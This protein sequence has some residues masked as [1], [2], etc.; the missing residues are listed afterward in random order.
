[1]RYRAGVASALTRL[2]IGLL[3]V[4]GA[5]SLARGECPGAFDGGA[6]PP[7]CAGS[8]SA[9]AVRFCFGGGCSSF[10][11]VAEVIGPPPPFTVTGLR[12]ENGAGTFPV[13]GAPVFLFP[14]NRLVIDVQA[15]LDGPGTAR[16]PLELRV[17]EGN[18]DDDDD[19][20]PSAETCRT[21]LEA[22]VPHCGPGGGG[23][24]DAGSGC[25]AG[26]CVP[27]LAGGVCDDGDP[28]TIGD[29]CQGG[30]CQP[31]TPKAC[32]DDPCVAGAQCVAGQCV[33]GTPLACDDG[34]PCTVDL[35]APGVG[36]IHAPD[37]G[38]CASADPCRPGRCNPNQGCVAQ[39]VSGPACD[40]AD[41]CTT[42]DRCTNGTCR[43]KAVVCSDGAACTD[44]R[45]EGGACVHV[46]VDSRCDGGNCTVGACRPGTPG[47]DKLGCVSVPVGEGEGCTDDGI[48]CTDDVC[49]AGGCLH[50]PVD[51]NCSA[52]TGD[53]CVLAACAPERLDHDAAGCVV[54]AVADGAECSED[55]DP[56][57]D[58]VCT[59]G[60]CRHTAV[61]EAALCA[62]IVA[63]FRKALGLANAA[64]TLAKMAAEARSAA[65]AGDVA[66]ANTFDDRLDTLE[67]Q[68]I[69]AARV[70]AGKVVPDPPRNGPLSPT[71]AQSRAREALRVL[72][73][74]PAQAQ[75]VRRL[76]TTPGLRK[77]VGGPMAKDLG[78]RGRLLLKGTKTLK[79]DLRR[80]LRFS[81]TFA[82]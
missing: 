77:A 5:P 51:Q 41:A 10:G 53:A 80:I 39:A 22:S 62:P 30:A 43:G 37:D 48:P 32:V 21:D 55:G 6:L 3:V 7:A 82:R 4:L 11:M 76:A 57:S 42:A 24:C 52:A 34:I 45:C 56:C 17:R 58:D 13:F 59:A 64:R 36:C 44:D 38:Q 49:T 50:V 29:T 66:A 25:V 65:G 71:S 61:V 16:E 47:T 8:P 78:R 72:R 27:L 63:P 60:A 15:R 69:R 20:G 9:G 81:E 70:L 33:G 74:A 75:A 28:C 12:V 2:S 19:D 67:A 35:C 14:G 79:G 46:P 1:L 26:A 40:D 73:R 54:A 18:D 68:L 31:G 23:P